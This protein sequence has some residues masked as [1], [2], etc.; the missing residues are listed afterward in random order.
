MARWNSCNVLQY[1][2][3]AC[4][5]W[6]FDGGSFNLHREQSCRAGEPLP[7]GMVAKS[8]SSLYQKK[9]NI[10]WLP[11]EHVFIRVAQFPAAAPDEMRSMVELQLEKLS[12]IPITQAVWTF[13]PVPGASSNM[14]TIVL[15]VVSRNVV[16]E[17]LGKL[18]TEGYLADRLELPLLDQLQATQINGDGAWIYPVES[19]AR[20]TAMVAWW[21]GS[22]LRNIDLLT[23]PLPENRAAGLRDQ[24]MQMAW[25][26]ELDG[27]LTSPPRWH[28]VADEAVAAE[29]QRPLQEGLEQSVELVSPLAPQQLAARTAKRAAESDPNTTLLPPEFAARYQQQFVDRLWMRGLGATLAVYVACVLI[30]FI[31]L[32]FL[33]YKTTGVEDQVRALGPSYTN[34]MQL[35]AQVKVLRERQELKYAA[36]D[37]WQAVAETMPAGLTLDSLNLSGGKKLSLS[38]TAPAEQLSTVIDFSDSLRRYAVNGQPLFDNRNVDPP[39]PSVQGSTIHWSYDLELK[40]GGE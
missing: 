6:Q 36:L 18:E 37:C 15:L 25:A 34:V 7:P 4:R 13:H 20:N 10:A 30:Y 1:N 8:W 35:T 9:L 12:P 14:Q 31:A 16:E 33:N 26:G 11:A 17:Y 39:R 3:D 22:A 21:Y 5:V 28:L 27:W 23:L 19:G 38:G 2:A 32:T 40:R 29:W 24:L